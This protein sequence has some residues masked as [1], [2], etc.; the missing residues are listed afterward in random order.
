MLTVFMSFS[1]I[2]TTFYVMNVNLPTR[3]QTALPIRNREYE[4]TDLNLCDKLI[5]RLEGEKGK[6]PVVLVN[7]RVY[8]YT[9]TSTT[10]ANK[11]KRSGSWSPTPVDGILQPVEDPPSITIYLEVLIVPKQQ[12]IHTQGLLKNF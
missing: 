3:L 1:I 10:P 5:E 2:S 6:Y 8:F 12:V 11:A 7:P 9:F 4:C